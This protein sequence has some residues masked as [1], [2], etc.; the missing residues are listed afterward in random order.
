MGETGINA[1]IAGY[2]GV[3]VTLVTG[4]RKLCG[5]ARTFLRKVVTVVVKEAVGRTA[6]RCISP[7]KARPLIKCGA[8]KAFGQAD[9]SKPFKTKPPINLK[10]AFINPGMAEVAELAPVQGVSTAERCL[11]P[12]RT[13]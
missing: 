12:Q 5:E 7:I 8:A 6:A 2:Y 13:C 11:I 4:D 9:K 10:I 1:A 3:P